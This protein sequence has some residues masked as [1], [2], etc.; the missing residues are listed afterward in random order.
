LPVL[1]IPGWWAG[2]EDPEFYTDKQ[3]FRPCP[4]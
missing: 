3:V 2:Q 1:G 4:S